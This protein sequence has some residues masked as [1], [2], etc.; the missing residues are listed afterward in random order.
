MARLHITPGLGG[1]EAKEWKHLLLRQY[2]LWLEREQ[3][4]FSQGEVEQSVFLE[5]D[6]FTPERLGSEIGVHQLVRVPPS[7]PL[8][9]RHTSFATVWLEGSRASEE[10]CRLYV[11]SPEPEV[12]NLRTGAAS[13]K[14][15]EVLDGWLE[16]AP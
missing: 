4:E 5:S 3:Q 10:T 1:P 13:T 11:L 16:H 8:G 12:R 14:V 15:L 9:R 6:W 2:R 7:D